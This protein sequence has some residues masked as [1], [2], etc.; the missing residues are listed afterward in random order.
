MLAVVIE[1]VDQFGCPHP[2]CSGQS[3]SYLTED[4]GTIVANCD[5]CLRQFAIVVKDGFR[6]HVHIGQQTVRLRLVKH[7][8]TRHADSWAS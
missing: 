7:R 8:G 1:E 3:Y 5:K 4:G 6:L 2:N